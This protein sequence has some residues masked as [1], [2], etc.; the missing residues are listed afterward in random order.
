VLDPT[1]QVVARVLA[2]EQLI[3]IL[4]QRAEGIESLVKFG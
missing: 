4:A 3:E 1:H 2:P